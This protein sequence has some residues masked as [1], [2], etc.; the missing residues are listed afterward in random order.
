MLYSTGHAQYPLVI[1]LIAVAVL[2][3]GIFFL[4]PM[5]AIGMGIAVAC[6]MA[7]SWVL[8]SATVLRGMRSLVL[9]E[10]AT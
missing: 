5:G 4:M 3:F 9:A 1:R 7:V 2:G 10:K 8:M 6:G